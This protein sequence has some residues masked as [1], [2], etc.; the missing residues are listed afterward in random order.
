MAAVH[1][2]IGQLKARLS[3]YLARA[4]AGEEVVI[5]DRGTPVAR[6]APLSGARA[7][8]GRTAELARAGLVREP[9]ARLDP[10]T[11]HAPRPQDPTGRS[12][13]AILEE[14]SEGW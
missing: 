11:F 3:E 6:L 7:L 9:S 8:E 14:R 10:A 13:A 4:R 12:L 1:V 2:P 5:T